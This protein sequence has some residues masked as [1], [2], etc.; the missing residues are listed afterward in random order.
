MQDITSEVAVDQLPPPDAISTQV[1]WLQRHGIDRL[2]EEGKQHWAA[3]ASRPDLAAIK[4]RS[5]VGEAEALLDLA[6]LG[7]FTVL[8]WRS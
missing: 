4:M 2:V 7:A 5:R 6:G 1:E 3:R 8:E